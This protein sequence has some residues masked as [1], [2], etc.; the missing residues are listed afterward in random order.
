MVTLLVV[1]TI[2]D[3]YRLKKTPL[4]AL[5]AMLVL[6]VKAVKVRDSK[7][8]LWFPQPQP[9][10]LKAETVAKWLGC[11]V[12]NVTDISCAKVVG[13]KVRRL[14]QV[15]AEVIANQTAANIGWLLGANP[16]KPVDWY[17]RPYTQAAFDD[18]Q[19]ELWRRKQ[20]RKFA[21]HLC[22]VNFA[23]GVALLG[24]IL[25]RAFQDGNDGVALRIT[26]TLRGLY[27]ESDRTGSDRNGLVG[28]YLA[29]RHKATRPDLRPTLAKWEAAFQKVLPV[30]KATRRR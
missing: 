2:V 13:G 28:S 26:D 21:A 4:A 22:Q 20:D 8:G 14:T 29:G 27:L 24:A 25:L 30:K 23:K 17:G 11:S 1:T 18:R 19:A 10:R 7:S 15:Q 9:A 5:R 3:K 12:Q 6:G 16:A